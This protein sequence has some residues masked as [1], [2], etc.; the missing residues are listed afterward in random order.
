MDLS[1]GGDLPRLL[2]AA[3]IIGLLGG[4]ET[5]SR[6]LKDESSKQ[7]SLTFCSPY[8]IILLAFCIQLSVY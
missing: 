8:V 4:V 3:E 2:V 5:P 7:A 1:C 6:N